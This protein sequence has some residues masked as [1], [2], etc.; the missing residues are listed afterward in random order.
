MNSRNIRKVPVLELKLQNK[1]DQFSEVLL[2]LSA[3]KA[4]KEKIQFYVMFFIF[5]LLLR[6]LC[7]KETLQ[8]NSLK[9]CNSN[10]ARWCTSA[11]SAAVSSPTELTIAGTRI[12]QWGTFHL[13]P[14]LFVSL[15]GFPSSLSLS[16]WCL[17]VIFSLLG[18]VMSTKAHEPS[19]V[20]QL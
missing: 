3:K 17:M 4:F 7:P 16:F 20:I 1:N 8:K 13:Q 10:Q 9:A 19:R 15:R 11:P 18:N 12:S 5:L 14:G 6:E 2:P